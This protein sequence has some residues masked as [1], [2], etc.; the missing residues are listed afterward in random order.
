MRKTTSM[1]SSS[2]RL[3]RYLTIAACGSGAVGLA[4]SPLHGDI[5]HFSSEFTLSL[6]GGSSTQGSTSWNFSGGGVSW[7]LGGSRSA[8]IWTYNR[9]SSWTSSFGSTRSTTSYNN[10][11]WFA[12]G[13]EIGTR[14]FGSGELIDL[15]T[16]QGA[17]STGAVIH[18]QTNWFYNYY[19]FSSSSAGEIWTSSHSSS[20]STS[21]GIMSPFDRGFLALSFDLDGETVYGWAAVTLSND[22]LS[23]SVDSWA[24]ED[25]GEGILAGQTEDATPVPG[26]G[27]LAAL[28]C[29]AAGLRRKRNRVA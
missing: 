3:E 14:L 20:G 4:V 26:I 1:S 23:L 12:S 21:T 29:G 17:A 5:Q 2:T 18:K 22:G 10:I 24:F 25:S 7:W 15:N 27:G 8:G 11:L 19:Y 13:A 9:T 28:A 6:P 16:M